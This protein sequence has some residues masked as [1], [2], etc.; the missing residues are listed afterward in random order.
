MGEPLTE[1]AKLDFLYKNDDFIESKTV[2]ACVLIWIDDKDITI[3]HESTPTE[4]LG[5]L[6][7]ARLLI[8]QTLC[9]QN[10]LEK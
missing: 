3:L 10:H 9:E 1:T 7:H 2:R 8:G 4:L 6:D 5:M